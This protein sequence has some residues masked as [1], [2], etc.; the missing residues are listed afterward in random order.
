MSNTFTS[1]SC[2]PPSS[3]ASCAGA[4]NGASYCRLRQF[5]SFSDSMCFSC[6][7][8]EEQRIVGTASPLVILVMQH[9]ASSHKDMLRDRRETPAAAPPSHAA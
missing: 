9:R 3:P 7:Q 4:K 8:E 2:V 1:R 6:G 5:D